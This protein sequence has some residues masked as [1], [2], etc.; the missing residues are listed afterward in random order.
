MLA[1]F[2]GLSCEK[3]DA[4][5]QEG[6]VSIDSVGA[7]MESAE[8]LTKAAYSFN[9]ITT[10]PL[11]DRGTAGWKLYF[12]MQ[13]RDN[14]GE[15][16]T[17]DLTTSDDKYYV[18]DATTKWKPQDADKTLKFPNYKQVRHGEFLLTT[19]S[20]F[21]QVAI[22]ENQS[23]ESTLLSA[24]DLFINDR[25]INPAHELNVSLKH[26][27]SMLD[28]YFE[29]DVLHTVKVKVGNT[30]YTPYIQPATGEGATNDGKR[31]YLLILPHTTDTNPVIEIVT[32]GNIVYQQTVPIITTTRTTY[33]RNNRYVFTF[34]GLELKLSPITLKDWTT[35]KSYPGEYIA[36]VAYPTFR[37]TVNTMYKV[38]YENDLSDQFTINSFGENTFKASGSK[39]TEVVKDADGDGNLENE[40]PM[41]VNATL[42]D[43]D[44]IVD[45]EDVLTNKR[46]IVNFSG[47]AN[48]T[49]VL[50]YTN[51]LNQSIN[52]NADGKASGI[53]PKGYKLRKIKR[54]A[55]TERDV[56]VRFC[57]ES[58]VRGTVPNQ[59][60]EIDLESY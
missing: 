5:E 51:G 36:I 26:A 57:T 22:P 41:V 54:D 15:W 45:L 37:G 32:T 58:P 1:V 38:T 53:V 4:T 3:N 19:N 23:T 40:T 33:G 16:A 2:A 44:M 6:M 56:S 17:A 14:D 46:V 31:H 47:I 29:T 30:E 25:K 13:C 52:A 18:Y 24:D 42:S 60:Y 7:S 59:Y 10:T 34:S 9:D 55:E 39:I 48:A 35:G 50:T 21:S 12:K 43:Y 28:F 11:A 8:P 27:N 20:D 49:Y